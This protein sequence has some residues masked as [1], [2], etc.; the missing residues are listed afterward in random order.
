MSEPNS[1]DRLSF[2]IFLAVAVHAMIIFGITF[3]LSERDKAAPTLNIT[4]ATHASA[5]EP[6]KADFLA[7]HNQ[8]A[9]GTETELKELTTTE[10]ADVSDASINEINP[11]PAQQASTPT[12]RQKQSLLSTT[13]EANRKLTKLEAKNQQS[14]QILTESNRDSAEARSQ[15]LASLQAKLSQQ[16]QAL[17]RSKPTAAWPLLRSLIHLA[18]AC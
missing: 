8:E 17:A 6:D 14:E 3:T 9:S 5:N 18:T 11:T 1:S 4:L 10:I 13:A 12:E 15:K 7:Q 16:R 2:T